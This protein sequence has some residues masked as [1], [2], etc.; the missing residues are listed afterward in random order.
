VLGKGSSPPS[1]SSLPQDL[2][3]SSL[4]GKVVGWQILFF[5]CHS[6]SVPY[7]GRR[8]GSPRRIAEENGEVGP[9]SYPGVISPSFFL[10]SVAIE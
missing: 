10:A 3:T 6:L 4:Q 9:S 5:R 8:A 7:R 1:S 2:I